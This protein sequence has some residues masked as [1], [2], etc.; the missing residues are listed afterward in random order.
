MQTRTKILEI[1]IEI[2]NLERSRLL[3]E[4]VFWPLG[5]SLWDPLS[6]SGDL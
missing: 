4:K 6:L 1:W 2:G 3:G 5:S